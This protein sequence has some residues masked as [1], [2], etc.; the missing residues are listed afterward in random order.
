MDIEQKGEPKVQEE[1]ENI[2][3]GAAGLNKLTLINSD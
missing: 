1:A 3:V 2:T